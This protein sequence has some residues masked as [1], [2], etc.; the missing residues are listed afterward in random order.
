MWWNMD[1]TVI[2]AIFFV[3]C[4]CDCDKL[5]IMVG[6]NCNFLLQLFDYTISL[7]VLLMAF[8]LLFL[9]QHGIEELGTI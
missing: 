8:I 2:Y 3:A 7:F 4:I 6:I 1:K 9:F 5:A